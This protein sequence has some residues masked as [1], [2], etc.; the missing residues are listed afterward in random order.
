MTDS[1]TKF[2][3][4]I[5]IFGWFYHHTDSLKEVRIVDRFV[6]DYVSEI[7]VSHGG[8]ESSL[9]PNKGFR[10]QALRNTEN[11]DEDIKLEFVTQNGWCQRVSLLDLAS[12]RIQRYRSSQLAREFVDTIISLPR[13][14]VLD[15]GG[16]ARSGLDRQ[17]DFPGVDYTVL[18]IL[19]GANVDVVGDAHELS[20]Y[21]QQEQFDAV[22]SVSVFE[23][24]LM[25]WKVAIEIN[26][27]LKIGGI[28]LI[29]SH[30]TLGVH[31][32][33]WDFWRFSDTAWS[34]IFNEKTGFEIIESTMDYEAFILPFIYRSNARDAERSAVCQCSAVKI[35]KVGPAQVAWDISL[36]E[37]VSSAYPDHDDGRNGQRDYF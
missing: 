20:K 3:N 36:S 10:L 16:R 18:D 32:M 6:R 23:H 19:P 30:Q 31:D 8:V 13:A 4:T 21:F 17:L 34:A 7:G 26:K 29:H 9:G 27:V 33:P 22:Y 12:D 28:G 25:P 35:R 24:L 37:V 11:F 14:R 2:H 5:Y 15:I 1:I